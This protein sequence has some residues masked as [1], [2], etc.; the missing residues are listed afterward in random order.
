MRSR[1]PLVRRVSRRVRPVRTPH[2]ADLAKH[3]GG[4]TSPASP[5]SR[6]ASFGP[7]LDR[8]PV[9][10]FRALHRLWTG[11][12]SKAFELCTLFSVLYRVARDGGSVATI[13]RRAAK[14]APRAIMCRTARF[15]PRRRE[16]L[17]M[18][19]R[20]VARVVARAAGG[21]Q[22]VAARGHGEVDNPNE[23]PLGGLLWKGP[24]KSL[25]ASF[26]GFAGRYTRKTRKRRL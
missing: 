6:G 12:R 21:A 20:V 24:V 26:P 5:A 22:L 1:L 16:A 9:Q 18:L 15:C 8:V 23:N 4:G 10:S 14:A 19:A 2:G 25:L 7:A 11:Y 17:D 13:T 3:R